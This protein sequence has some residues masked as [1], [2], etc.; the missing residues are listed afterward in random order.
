MRLCSFGGLPRPPL[1]DAAVPGAHV[2]ADVAAVDAVAER[3]AVL[4]RER[5]GRLR[6]VREAAGGVEHAGLLQRVGRARV[7]AERAGAAA[8]VERRRRLE[9]GSRDERAEHHPGAMPARDQHRVLP[10]EA[11]AR[12]RSSLA[13][14]VLVCI[15]EHAVLAAEPAAE[16]VQALTQH[17]VRVPPGVARQPPVP[18]RRLLALDPVAECGRDDRARPREQRLRMARDLGLGHGEAHLAEQPAR[19]ALADVPLGLLVWRDRQ[20]PRPRRGRAPPPAWPALPPACGR[21]CP[22]EGDPDPRGRRARGPALRGRARS[23]ARAGRGA[24]PSARRFSQPSRP[25]DPQGPPFGAQ[26]AD[27]RRGRRGRSRGHR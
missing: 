3:L 7:D 23:R 15:H 24:R 17:R 6:P 19:A 12:A 27:P 13:V 5:V 25:L 22:D 26:A 11:D 1:L 14:D 10:V 16:L 4:L 20:P 21:L 2:L 8:G 9:L 18:R